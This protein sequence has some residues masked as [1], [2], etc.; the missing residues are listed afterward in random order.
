MK[1]LFFSNFEFCLFILI[2]TTRIGDIL[3]TYLLTPKLLLEAN[4]VVRKFKWPFALVTLL[5]A[6]LPYYHTGFAVSA[7]IVFAMVCFSNIS[8]IWFVR[9]IGEEEYHNIILKLIHKSSLTSVFIPL[10]ISQVFFSSIGLLIYLFLGEISAW[11][12]YIALGFPLFSIAMIF[13]SLNFYRHL[14]R[15]NP[16]KE[17]IVI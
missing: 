1:Q 10:L 8:K 9:T 12:N 3:S 11:A 5:A 4:F 15:K 13:H 6:F 2:L 7:F 14:K 17:A 16:I